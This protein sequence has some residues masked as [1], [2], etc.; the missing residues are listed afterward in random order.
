MRAQKKLPTAE[1]AASG[2]Y[3]LARFLYVYVNKRPGESVA[4]LER[5]FLRLIL[6]R[7]GQRIV[8]KDGYVPLPPA[9]AREELTRLE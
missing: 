7:Q 4:P 3:P 9:V 2:E 6:S 5:E 8:L 1:T